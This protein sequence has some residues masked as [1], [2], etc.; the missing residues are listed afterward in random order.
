MGEACILGIGGGG[1]YL[2][3]GAMSQMFPTPEL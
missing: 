2:F 3:I 1:D